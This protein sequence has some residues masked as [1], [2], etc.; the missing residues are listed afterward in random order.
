MDTPTQ[1]LLVTLL[2]DELEQTIGARDH[3]H[4]IR[5]DDVAFEIA[6]EACSRL[7]GR[8][9][10]DD[11]AVVVM[12]T[13]TKPHHRSPGQVV[14]LRNRSDD[15]GAGVL[16]VF[17]PPNELLSVEDS[18]GRSTFQRVS[19]DLGALAWD[20]VI[21]GLGK[22]SPSAARDIDTV[23]AILLND[24]DRFDVDTDDLPA[25]AL[26]VQRLLA[27]GHNESTVVGA[28]L[29]VL[30]LLPDQDAAA[31]D[32]FDD[33]RRRMELNAQQM[34]SLSQSI[35]PADR[36]RNLP[37]DVAES[38]ELVTAL[39]EAVRDGTTDQRAIAR[40]LADS[41]T[42]IDL[43]HWNVELDAQR[44]ERFDIMRLLG[45]ERDDNEWTVTDDRPSLGVEF[46]CEPAP[47]RFP[48]ATLRLDIL[49]LGA[50]DEQGLVKRIDKKSL[51]ANT[52]GTF[53]K[54]MSCGHDDADLRPGLY[55]I[56]LSLIA[57]D[58]STLASKESE[59]FRVGEIASESLALS[60]VHTPFEAHLR[61]LVRFK[62][63]PGSQ[64]TDIH[65][66]ANQITSIEVGFSGVEDVRWPLEL[67]PRLLEAE[68]ELLAQPTSI[69]GRAVDLT[70]DDVEL[71]LLV[72]DDVPG[73][74]LDKRR[75]LFD[76][77][78]SSCRTTSPDTPPTLSSIDLSPHEAE[79]NDY[80]RAWAAALADD[81]RGRNDVLEIDR[82]ELRENGETRELLL[83]PTHPVRLAWRLRHDQAVGSWLEAAEH[84]DLDTL[85]DESEELLD[86]V[87]D[88]VGDELPLVA[89]SGV[90]AHRFLAPLAGGWVSYTSVSNEFSNDLA[91]RWLGITTRNLRSA[92]ER[93]LGAQVRGYLESHPYVR[94]LVLN[95]VRGG[96]GDFVLRL[97]GSLATEVDDIRF[98]VRFFADDTSMAAGLA[99]DEF[100][101]DPESAQLP[102]AARDMLSRSG[103]DS[104]RPRLAFS[105]HTFDDLRIH[106][107]QF[108]A[109]LTVFLDFFKTDPHTAPKRTTG[110]S[111][112]GLGL[113][114]GARS[115]FRAS[116][117][118]TQSPPRWISQ[119]V[120]DVSSTDPVQTALD[121]H[122]V[123]TCAALGS[124]A[125]DVVPAL[126]LE[127]DVPT[128]AILDAVH[129]SS[130]WVVVVDPIFSDQ[131]LDPGTVDPNVQDRYVVDV[132][133][134][135]SAGAAR[136]V[137]VSS[138][139]R[140][141]QSAA[142]VEAARH[143]N[144]DVDD[145]TRALLLDGLHVLGAGLGLRLLADNSRRIEAFSLA[146]ASNF[147]QHQGFLRDALVLPLD[148]Y[149][150]LFDEA[151]QKGEVTSLSRTD[152]LIIRLDPDKRHIA[153]TLVE[154]KVRNLGE[155][156]AVTETL[157][158]TIRSQLENTEPVVRN[159]LFT[160]QLR[161]RADSLAATLRL[162]RLSDILRRHL[163]RAE[164]HGYLS[165]DR[166][167]AS[168]EFIDH[169]DKGLAFSLDKRGLIFNV[170][171]AGTATHAVGGIE[172]DVVGS[173]TIL[174][175]L[176]RDE[177]H[178]TVLPLPSRYF[179][180]VME[181]R[182][183]IIPIVDAEPVPDKELLDEPAGVAPGPETTPEQ[184]SEPDDTSVDVQ[185][186]DL[187]GRDS[188]SGQFSIIGVGVDTAKPVALDVGGT[189]V[190]TLFG[191]QG[192]GKS[193]TSGVII[194]AGL[195]PSP[196]LGPL[197][198]PLATVVFHYSAD[199]SY[200]SEFASMATAATDPVEASWADGPALP[201]PV[202]EVIVLV[203]E[204]QIDKRRT[205]YPNAR[206][207]PLSI[208]P[209]E[210]T[211]ANWKLL[212][213]IEGGQQMYAKALNQVLRGLPDNFTV[214]D[215]RTGIEQSGLSPQQKSIATQR[216]DFV[217]E[218]LS[219]AAHVVD[220]IRPGRLVIVDLRDEYI[221]K[222]EA[223]ALFMVLLSR[224]A[225]AQPIAARGLN[226]MIVFDEAHK[227]M[228][229]S[230]LTD[231]ITEAV[232]EMRHKGVTLV[233]A[234]QDPP[235]IPAV[236]I[237]LSTVL[238]VHK[239]TS[240]NW[241][242]HLQRYNTAFADIQTGEVAQLRP[243]NA[244]V[245]SAGGANRFRQ[246]QRIQT[247]H[248]LT[249]HGGGTIRADE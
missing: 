131:Y 214:G 49:A 80:L 239:M 228:R 41:P 165:R 67:H 212:M 127:L 156:G 186:V 161:E 63:R 6:D 164:R 216:V 93:E 68:S 8:L 168:Y 155:N 157:A 160:A 17:I 243:G 105:K 177:P 182:A 204:R 178:D 83:A 5:V 217:D 218:Y 90:E 209:A 200:R 34:E 167:I 210:L 101:N 107:A 73:E 25:F 72:F 137:V 224:F 195:I 21:T 64:I 42:A 143:F 13:P 12:D 96:R 163:T 19:V 31:S 84:L 50:G 153:A 20:H 110:R 39:L 226:K 245:W 88:L 184:P 229:D 35:A 215:L 122:N 118:A 4:C 36:I 208:G 172:I 53:R 221:D 75:Q 103:K 240:P 98:V 132:R 134:I 223:L 170:A 15:P 248:R 29:P 114:T 144:L 123:H 48:D 1:N 40:R 241:L 192:S 189:N 175:A 100:M 14:E 56:Q 211:S 203:A 181:A 135:R 191:V 147:L 86:T 82:I 120:P 197:P 62:K 232:R 115:E 244:F 125:V 111:I 150:E 222:E 162:R 140:V 130:D 47:R 85:I 7:A 112:F 76:R 233:I 102:R 148:E 139:L 44:P 199:S 46:I 154:V 138:E 9:E 79:I 145:H 59:H 94:T 70:T 142:L 60:A 24:P 174:D 213:G 225:E 201:Q 3:G 18:I 249:I 95:V 10:G 61:A 126:R 166:A 234:S 152:L 205:E 146:L 69:R 133:D 32:D 57:F 106:P 97:L 206:V 190:V 171:G 188:S 71:E 230:T 246:P 104:L 196:Q 180:T 179:R 78:S 45:A 193:Y 28:A 52:R 194:E 37:I 51:P 30:G 227:Y 117:A 129:R 247:R 55:Q 77:L 220:W 169:L 2:A 38:P 235:S 91:N 27:A 74:F 43:S 119:L 173:S 158:D 113:V 198:N 185:D 187:I 109:H 16:A 219:E 22:S 87:P 231:A 121:T 207:E 238:V 66:D 141:E 159:R 81:P 237:E 99:L 236:I 58:G 242:R 176:R 183:P 124:D 202:D 128:Q 54:Q 116:D 11:L 89:T 136:N 108:P 92:G 23:R 149:P 65:G 26:E 33:T 151:K